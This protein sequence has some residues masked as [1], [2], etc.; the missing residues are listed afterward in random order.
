[1]SSFA[2]PA[3]APDLAEKIANTIRFLSADGV[4]A[5]N[6]G[7]PGMPMGCA[8]IATV[9]LTRFLRID[10]ADVNWFNRDRFVLSAGHGSMLQY[11]M[12]YL[13]GVLPMDELKKF[14]QLGSLTPGHPES[15]EVPG[16]DVTGGPLAAGFAAAAGL[17]LAERMLA[18]RYNRDADEVIDHFT[19]VIMGDGCNME[20]LSQEAASLA[21]HLKLAKLI[22]I[23]DD[24]EISIEGST[25]LAFTENVNA[26]YEAIGWHVQDIDGHD[27]EAIGRAI[28]A[29]QAETEK[30]SI[31]VA[32][33]T[34]GKGAPT[35]GGTAKS[36]GE[37]LGEEEILAAKKAIGW[38][39]EPFHVPAEVSEYFEK[40]KSEW[41]AIRGEYNKRFDAYK[42]AHADAAA[43][44]D[45]ITSGE[46]PDDW[47]AATLA[48]KPDAKGIA[49]R[50]SGGKVLNAFASVI[51]ELVGG[52]ADLAPSTKTEITE[53]NWTDFVSAGH[54]A[55]RNIHFGVREHA[56]GNM[57]NGL[58][59][60]GLI[61]FGATFMVFHDYMRPAV[62]L[63]ALQRCG[64]I[65]VYTHDSFY[66]GEDGP[67]HQPVEQIAS[68]RAIPRVHVMRP[69]DAN[70]VAF[71]WQYAIERRDAPT[72]LALTRQNLPTLDRASLGPAES[73]LLGGYVLSNDPDATIML[74]ATGSEVHLAMQ[75]AEKLRQDGAA[76]R[77]VSMP[78]L[79][80]FHEQPEEYQNS[81]L[82]KSITKR[83]VLEAGVRLGWEGIIGW[84]GLFVGMSDF[85]ASGPYKD[86]EEHFGFTAEKVLQR[87]KKAW[88]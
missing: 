84:D 77:V 6:S 30:P 17:V 86:L 71:A 5:A 22:A 52:S 1:M 26:R 9:L 42:K 73:T 10:P 72:A 35:R 74:V 2:D 64:S 20:G 31:I 41:A 32:H 55:G 38:P 44:L 43:G 13:S 78:C 11:S 65:F 54:Y 68:M 47:K 29:A 24:N 87:I 58:A 75:V 19:Y 63:A 28:I 15:A 85:G 69:C 36:H 79:D 62:R 83:V 33:T 25:D 3:V 45:R 4:Q 39:A 59:L 67:T 37:P 82:P 56:M 34:I 16:V 70:E 76:V 48:F 8:D 14:R 60:H 66:V 7:H 80:L 50:A 23:Y 51:D 61:P 46:L 49:T 40:R 27:H 21:G 53:G 81:V 12:L 57:V 18:E 88:F